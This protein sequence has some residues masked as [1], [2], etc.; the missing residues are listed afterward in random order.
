MARTA[1]VSERELKARIQALTI[2]LQHVRGVTT[3]AL[4]QA[5]E[6]LQPEQREHAPRARRARRS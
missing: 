1:G 3:I 6:L 4:N 2:S 5:R